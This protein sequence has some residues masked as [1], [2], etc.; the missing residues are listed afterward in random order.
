MMKKHLLLVGLSILL[1]LSIS[2]C[3]AQTEIPAPDAASSTSSFIAEGQL[4]PSRALDLAFGRNGF[5]AEVLVQ[6]G[7]TV[8]SGQA[9]A[10]LEPSP[11]ALQALALAKQEALKAQQAMDELMAVADLDL[12]NMKSSVFKAQQDVDVAQARYDANETDTNLAKLDG[13]NA[14][15]VILQN[16]LAKMEANDG[17]DPD[18]LAAADARLQASKATLAN[19]ES[20]VDASVLRAKLDGT[21]VDLNLQPGDYTLLGSTVGAVADFHHWIIKT[22]NLTEIDVVTL[23]TGQT[24]EVTLDAIPGQTFAGE[25]INIDARFVENRGDITYTVTIK[26]NE[27]DPRMRWGMTAAVKFSR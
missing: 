15:L 10:S 1:A 24:V 7:D 22:D 23:E 2:A 14:Q 13:A 4:A 19:A 5:V 21:V 27:S 17:I 16:I 11:D 9:L 25:I 8:T 26:L 18:K 3:R 12:A 20:D 6:N